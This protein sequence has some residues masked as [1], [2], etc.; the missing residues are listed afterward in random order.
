MGKIETKKITSNLIWGYAEKTLTYAISIITSLILARILDPSVYGTVTLL[1]VIISFLQ[2]LIDCGLSS[3]LI[4]KKDADDLDFSTIFWVN[5]FLAVLLYIGLVVFAENIAQFYNNEEITSMLKFL[6]FW[7]VVSAFKNVQMAYITKH[8][9][10]KTFFWASLS[11]TLIAGVV[12]IYMALN[13]FGGY[14][15]VALH[16]IDA[17]IDAIVTWILIKFRPSFKF[18]FER[19][20]QLFNYGSKLLIASFINDGYNDI[21]SL[22]IGKIYSTAD[23]AFYE[24][25]KRYPSVIQSFVSSVVDNTNFSVMS[26]IQDEKEKVKYYAKS[27][28]KLSTYIICPLMFGLAAVSNAIITILLTEKWQS[29]VPY[30]IIFCFT[31]STTP[32]SNLNLNIVRSLGLSDILLK[33]EIIKKLIAITIMFVLL[34]YG[35]IYVAL[36][37]L[38]YAPIAV[39]INQKLG[40]DYIGYSIGEQFKDIYLNFISALVMFGFVYLFNFLDLPIIVKL[41]IQVIV[42]ILVYLLESIIFKNESFNILLKAIKR[43]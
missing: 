1:N 5:M 41:I 17:T 25:G 43:R 7:I 28:L 33:T 14:S 26:S 30:M 36:G 10:Y 2:I 22:A 37:E 39:I 32:I 20:K 24:K 42:G 11:G 3:A 6:G 13:G 19:L 34:P 21:R 29:A 38:I 9:M 35:P 8:L 40:S 15:L 12:S 27:T 31:S 23:F 16:V 18:S 4:Q